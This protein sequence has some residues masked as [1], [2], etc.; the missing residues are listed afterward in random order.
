MTLQTLEK[1]DKQRIEEKDVARGEEEEREAASL[2]SILPIVMKT[3]LLMTMKYHTV[4][5][6]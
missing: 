6:L 4:L 5:K 3:C 1:W 2:V